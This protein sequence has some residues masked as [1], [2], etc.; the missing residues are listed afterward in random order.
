MIMCGDVDYNRL[1]QV[2][3]QWKAKKANIIAIAPCLLVGS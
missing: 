2:N 3:R 1:N